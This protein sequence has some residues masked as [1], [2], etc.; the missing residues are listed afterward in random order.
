MILFNAINN[1]ILFLD[2]KFNRTDFLIK[3]NTNESI[4]STIECDFI[5]E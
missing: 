5:D 4:L 3:Y 2:K 1:K